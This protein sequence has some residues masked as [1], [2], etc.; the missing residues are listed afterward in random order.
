MPFSFPSSSW[1][2]LCQ[3]VLSEQCLYQAAHLALQSSCKCWFNFQVDRRQRLILQAEEE[4]NNDKSP[5]QKT[6]PDSPGKLLLLPGLLSWFL[7]RPW[8]SSPLFMFFTLFVCSD[9]VQGK[10]SVPSQVCRDAKNSWQKRRGTSSLQC[11]VTIAVRSPYVSKEEGPLLAAEYLYI[12]LGC[13][14]PVLTMYIAL[15]KRE[16]AL[17]VV[18][19]EVI[20][21]TII[22]RTWRKHLIRNQTG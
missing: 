4:S 1:L 7:K 10:G 21:A 14:L 6:D 3:A 2:T 15:G 12:S 16:Q 19:Q 22:F 11:L 18:K 5:P 9:C 13:L 8:Y 20:L 17:Q